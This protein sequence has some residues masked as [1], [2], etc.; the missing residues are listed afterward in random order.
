M[1]RSEVNRAIEEALAFFGARGF[2]LPPWARWTPA[3]WRAAAASSAQLRALGLGWDVTDFGSGSFAEV[4]LVLFTVRN[5]R[6]DSGRSYCEKVMMVR[7]GQTTPWHFHWRKTEDIINRGGGRL[8]VR[9]ARAGTD[10][11]RLDERPVVVQVDGFDRDVP[12]GGA[13]LLD[14]GES[15]TLPPRLYHE[16]RAQASEGPVL[17]G[18]VSTVNDDATDNRFLRAPRRFPEIEE[19]EA[20]RFLLCGENPPSGAA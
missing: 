20:A 11:S 17:C 12:C 19:D 10:E 4:G 2:H 8:E 16:F 18:E 7:P 1:K 3:Q 14:P 13:V 9:V 6:P 5:G 15:I